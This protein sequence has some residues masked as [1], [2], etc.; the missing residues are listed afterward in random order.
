M[1]DTVEDVESAWRCATQVEVV[2]SELPQ[3]A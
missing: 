1:K 2:D 3:A